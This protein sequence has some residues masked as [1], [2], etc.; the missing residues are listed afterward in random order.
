MWGGGGGGGILYQ[1][2]RQFLFVNLGELFR[3]KSRNYNIGNIRIFSV[4]IFG[5]A[6]MRFNILCHYSVIQTPGFLLL[7]MVYSAL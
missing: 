1:P 3:G 4:K 6:V 7:F 2:S 5:D